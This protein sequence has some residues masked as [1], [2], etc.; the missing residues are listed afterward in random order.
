MNLGQKTRRHTNLPPKV[1]QFCDYIWCCSD[2]CYGN[3]YYLDHIEKLRLYPKRSVRIVHR[4]GRYKSLKIRV[5]EYMKIGKLIA[6]AVCG[7]DD[8]RILE[9]NHD[10]SDR[11]YWENTQAFYLAVVDGKRKTTDLTLLCPTCHKR[12]HKDG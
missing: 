3:Q 10:N 12:F 4:K 1:V 7:E 8:L 9:I 6:C 2:S 11:E 5:F